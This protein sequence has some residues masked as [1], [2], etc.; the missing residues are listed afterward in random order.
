M[1]QLSALSRG[2]DCLNWL[3]DEVTVTILL[4]FLHSYVWFVLIS[5]A[6]QKLFG[7]AWAQRNGGFLCMPTLTVPWVCIL[8][9]E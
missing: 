3:S 1:L 2:F 8:I 5:P 6:L 9:M 7:F 4:I